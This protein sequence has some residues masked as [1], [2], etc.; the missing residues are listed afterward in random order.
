MNTAIEISRASSRI[1]RDINRKF[2]NQLVNSPAWGHQISYVPCRK[3]TRVHY[4][5]VCAHY[6]LTGDLTPIL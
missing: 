2:Q 4:V 1:K 6:V 5:Q 3:D